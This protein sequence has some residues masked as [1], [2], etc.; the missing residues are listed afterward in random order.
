MYPVVSRIAR[1]AMPDRTGAM[2]LAGCGLAWLA[3]LAGSP[4]GRPPIG[5]LEARAIAIA[6]AGT[7][8]SIVKWYNGSSTP[9]VTPLN[10]LKIVRQSLLA[11]SLA[12]VLGLALTPTPA[13][14]DTA[15]GNTAFKVILKPVTLLYYY[16][17]VDL[18]IPQN[19]LLTLAGGAPAGLGAQAA[20]ASGTSST[21]SASL[22]SPAGA[23]AGGI[24]S[25]ALTLNNFWA[26]RSVTTPASGSTTVSV[27]FSSTTASTTATLTGTSAGST[28]TIG[29]S[30]L[31]TSNGSFT[32]TGLGGTPQTGNV[33]M[34]MNLSN[35]STA[36]TYAGATITITATST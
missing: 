28:A 31:S 32:G 20:T 9:E 29:L 19:A 7:E 5:W 1:N 36:D 13:A 6:K 21:L 34:N 25:A 11:T 15:T 27:S 22:T 16:S 17:E 35:A 33:S 30:G 8:T 4:A 2:R 26:V 10:T 18:T 3:G 23:V 14:A 24:T 12:I